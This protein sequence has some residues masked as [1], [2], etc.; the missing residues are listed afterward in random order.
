[1][2]SFVGTNRFSSVCSI[3]STDD[4][5]S[6]FRLVAH[7][8]LRAG[9]GVAATGEA[10]LGKRQGQGRGEDF[11]GLHSDGGFYADFC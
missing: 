3:K 11:L 10:N 9:V 5:G 2:D 4:G 7:L 1:M 6:H 8:L